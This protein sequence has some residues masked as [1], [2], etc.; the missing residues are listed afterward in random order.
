MGGFILAGALAIGAVL[1]TGGHYDSDN[2]V[3][4]FA[5]PSPQME[6]VRLAIVSGLVTL[7]VVREYFDNAYLRLVWTACAAGLLWTGITYFLYRTDY[8]IDSM[9]ML[10]AGIYFALGALQRAPEPIG[11]PR[12]IQALLPSAISMYYSR[13][14]RPGGQLSRL[15]QA[16]DIRD[17][18]HRL[19]LQRAP[20]LLKQ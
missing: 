8:L 16:S 20:Q 5:N 4:W 19:T 13:I 9:F 2:M 7:A 11:V 17:V 6:A 12:P 10:L 15:A 1:L 3:M 14:R 18:N